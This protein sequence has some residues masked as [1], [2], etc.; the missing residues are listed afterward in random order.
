MPGKPT[1]QFQCTATSKRTGVRCEA[2]RMKGKD[3]CRSHGGKSLGGPGSPRWKDGGRS[4]YRAIF[5]GTALEHYEAA[6]DDPRYVELREEIALLDTLIFQEALKAKI[7]QSGPLWEDLRRAWDRFQKAADEQ[8]VGEAGRH[9]QDVGRGIREGARR[10]AAQ[11]E[12]VDLVERKRRLSD[13]ERR[14]IVDAQQTVTQQQAMAFVGA[15]VASVR[16]HVTDR[17]VL[18]GIAAD[19]SRLVHS[20]FTSE[21]RERTEP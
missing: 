1:L 20:E 3:V 10:H 19:I 5:E 12:A 8:V 7:G 13:S 9:L 21:A 14:R 15:V 6:R 17:E 11:R 18:A 16:K 4:K 2:W